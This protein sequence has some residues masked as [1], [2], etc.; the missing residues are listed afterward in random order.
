MFLNL[1]LERTPKGGG[2]RKKRKGRKK[3]ERKKERRKEERKEKKKGKE[4]K[5]LDFWWPRCPD[6]HELRFEWWDGT[7]RKEER[8]KE[9]RVAGKWGK[10]CFSLSFYWR[11]GWGLGE[12]EKIQVRFEDVHWEGI[13]IYD[14]WYLDVDVIY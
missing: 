14:E 3:E 6:G 4:K 2:K 13:K 10:F 1:G 8:K 9:R 11:E 5:S 7:E 12:K